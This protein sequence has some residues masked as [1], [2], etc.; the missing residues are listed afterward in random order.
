[1]AVD[2]IRWW[3]LLEQL[4]AEHDDDIFGERAAV[5]DL[6]EIYIRFQK[7]QHHADPPQG[8]RRHRPEQ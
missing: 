8:E 7:E 1:M 3:R 4:L 6:G 2:D 5:L